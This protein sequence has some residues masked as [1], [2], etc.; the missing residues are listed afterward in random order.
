[1]LIISYSWPSHIQIKIQ[2]CRISGSKQ[3]IKSFCQGHTLL[4]LQLMFSMALGICLQW[5]HLHHSGTGGV[6]GRGLSCLNALPWAGVCSFSSLG[7]L[8]PH[9]NPLKVSFPHQFILPYW[10]FTIN[11]STLLFFF[12]KRHTR[13]WKQ[14]NNESNNLPRKIMQQATVFK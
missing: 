7:P 11:Y 4:L 5:P 3:F 13:Q 10:Y 1:M 9:I 6:R 14:Q 8:D 12:C 2:S